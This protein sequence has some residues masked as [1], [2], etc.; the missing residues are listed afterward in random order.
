M[1]IDLRQLMGK[2]LGKDAETSGVQSDASK[3]S[4]GEKKVL[5][6]IAIPAV[7]MAGT[8]SHTRDFLAE[9][10]RLVGG[11]GWERLAQMPE[12][13]GAGTTT[14]GILTRTSWSGVLG[15]AAKISPVI[16]RM[17][18]NTASLLGFVEARK[19]LYRYLQGGEGISL[20]EMLPPR[21]FPAENVV[22]EATTAGS[23]I[24]KRLG[25]VW[26]KGTG[27]KPVSSQRIGRVVMRHPAPPA[28]RA[29][30]T[31]P[32]QES[33]AIEPVFGSTT[34]PAQ[35]TGGGEKPSGILSP[36]TRAFSAGRDAIRR[37]LKI[38]KSPI[39]EG[40]TPV[41][42]AGKPT[43]P[44]VTIFRKEAET[45]E[46]PAMPLVEEIFEREAPGTAESAEGTPAG[47]ATEVPIVP[48]LEMPALGFSRRVAEDARK[49]VPDL[50]KRF[51]LAAG[52][53][54]EKAPTEARKPTALTAGM[55]SKLFRS[56]AGMEMPRTLT[57]VEKLIREA[58]NKP[59]SIVGKIVERLATPEEKEIVSAVERLEKPLAEA[60]ESPERAVTSALGM[61]SKAEEIEKTLSRGPAAA[62]AW[63]RQITSGL[64]KALSIP[65]P[66]PSVGELEEEASGTIESAMPGI[67]GALEL[68]SIGG[69]M[70]H[71]MA[72]LER[73]VGLP[74][75]LERAVAHPL[76]AVGRSVGLP[77][78]PLA[79]PRGA[80]EAIGGIERA[81]GQAE[82][83]VSSAIPMGEISEI[84]SKVVGAMGAAEEGLE[85]LPD[86]DDLTDEIYRR[87]VRRLKM[88][89][90]I[91]GL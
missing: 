3:P 14:S 51:P 58:K 12:W 48:P 46:T 28:P 73:A 34:E 57:G 23:A 63:A 35:P 27:E 47:E 17:P 8:L 20:D 65:L 38:A 11:V 15:G 66:M 59:E 16:G 26:G 19:S 18:L 36:I 80:Q 24:L 2:M 45:I 6:E 30:M 67:S 90:E 29:E 75:S 1:K 82:E 62:V 10:S 7:E 61:G 88:E 21:S 56:F 81:A 41:P 76:E 13:T 25:D 33:E 5:P 69:I 50:G 42:S 79:T 31:L 32:W 87:L 77:E 54:L 37:V 49:I 78:M 53:L 43:A 64:L 9:R 91:R 52:A 60:V 74:G 44:P 84:E 72:S 22:G 86:L 68:P 40:T 83:A 85:K 70:E 89:R 71:P 39:P 4:S 55:T